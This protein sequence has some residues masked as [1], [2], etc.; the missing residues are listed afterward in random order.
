MNADAGALARAEEVIAACRA[1]GFALAGIALARPSDHGDAFRRWI[2]EGCHGPMAYL[3][4]EPGRRLDPRILLPGARSVVCV[5]DRY[6]DGRPDRRVPGTGRIA[7]YA[8]GEDYHVVIRA[9]LDALADGLQRRH[10]S[11]RFRACVDTAP[12]MEREHAE[13]A[14][15]GRIG[16][17]TC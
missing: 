15:L 16:K 5:A 10:P 17:H 1:L 4:E 2:A 9:R 13:R 3:A 12:V 6:A 11:E 8:R 14:G 7:R